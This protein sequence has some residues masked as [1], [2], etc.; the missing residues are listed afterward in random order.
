MAEIKKNY[1][2]IIKE[3]TFLKN[4][5]EE[6]KPIK[7]IETA[8]GDSK[9]VK[10]VFSPI[11]VKFFNIMKNEID[12]PILQIFRLENFILESETID[13]VSKQ[14]ISNAIKYFQFQKFRNS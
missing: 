4:N 9:K 14:D 2:K 8:D 5:F 12:V 13:N 7:L 10:N 6:G 11:F 1:K 3:L